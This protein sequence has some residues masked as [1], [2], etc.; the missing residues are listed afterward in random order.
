V[1]PEGATPGLANS[2]VVLE[3]FTEG[4]WTGPDIVHPSRTPSL[5]RFRFKEPGTL[6]IWLVDDR[7]REVVILQP[8]VSVPPVGQW[9]WGSGSPAPPRAGLY[10]LCLRWQDASGSPVRRCRPVWVEP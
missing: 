2:L 5:F 10:F 9:V 8:P 6:G 3:S 4:A 7:G 1:D